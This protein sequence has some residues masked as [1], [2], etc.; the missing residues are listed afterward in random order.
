MTHYPKRRTDASYQIEAGY[1]NGKN[2]T[3]VDQI[4]DFDEAMDAAKAVACRGDTCH[5]VMENVN[6]RPIFICTC[7]PGKCTKH[8]DKCPGETTE[9]GGDTRL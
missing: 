1:P 8:P 6:A 2:N 5:A 4:D 7:R 9:I 3:I